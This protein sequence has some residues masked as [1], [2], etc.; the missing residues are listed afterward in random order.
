MSNWLS[1]K[2]IKNR[3]NNIR[4]LT[5]DDNNVE[6]IY[7]AL[8]DCPDCD[9]DEIRQESKDASCETCGGRGKVVVETSI[10][11]LAKIRW[12]DGIEE[13]MMRTGY[14]PEGRVSFTVDNI[15]ETSVDEAAKIKIQSNLIKIEAKI[16]KGRGSTNRITYIGRTI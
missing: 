10:F 1:S 3:I 12:L 11:V 16:P 5:S 13:N 7:E 6:L 15:F 9:Y 8:S 2:D 14:L 4:K